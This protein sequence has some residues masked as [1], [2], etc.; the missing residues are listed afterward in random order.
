MTHATPRVLV[1]DDSS[2]IRKLVE[3]SVR[4]LPW[5]VD[6]AQTGAEGLER[7]R[8]LEP[9]TILLDVVLPDL[10]GLDV[11]QSL[12]RDERTARASIVLMTGKD[13][14]I[15]EQ[16]REHKQVVGYL[17]KPFTAAQLLEQLHGV[18]A[19]APALRDRPRPSA[20]PSDAR[21][22]MAQALYTRLKPHLAFIPEWMEQLGSAQPA[23][24]FAR[25]LLSP[26][27]IDELVEALTPHLGV[28]A[29][30]QRPS[31]PFAGSVRGFPLL[32]I[33]RALAAL[34]QRS[35]VL[36]LTHAP[37]RSWLYFRRGA[38][39]L[40]TTDDVSANVP[41]ES[42]PA[43]PTQRERALD[44]QRASGKPYLVSLAESGVVPSATL[45][46]VLH[47]LGSR[48]LARL[49]DAAELQFSW[50]EPPTLPLFVEANGRELSLDQL[51][52]EHLR[53]APAPEVEPSEAV[54]ERTPGFSRRV[55]HFS[56][57]AIER[58]VLALVDGSH[59]TA[60]ICRRTGFGEREVSAVL[61]RLL[62]VGLVRRVDRARAGHKVVVIDHGEVAE[63]L[64]PLLA[65]LPGRWTV[66][67]F[68]PHQRDLVDAV[69]REAP[70]VL[71]ICAGGVPPEALEALAALAE[72][73]ATRLRTLV[74]LED[75]KQLQVESLLM[76]GFDHVLVK[77]VSFGEIER[78]VE[79]VH[80]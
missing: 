58:S 26:E 56:L 22:T 23:A 52:L 40:V 2:T 54:F 10:R 53:R 49:V 76:S 68:P 6:Y 24:F 35:G 44:E 50:S 11:C 51:K 60:R 79:E 33:L 78:I 1:I 72:N 67:A 20:L 45:P 9:D 18:A 36:E 17:R 5:L 75:K 37:N 74:V 21:N 32:E 16:F 63:P 31:A 34:D 48:Q 77:P 29:T 14:R 47:E 12:A 15:R 38:L 7:A 64:R 73:P 57:T 27:L 42:D 66:V 46:T 65:R 43:T 39:V 8:A 55:R 71:V 41:H 80:G 62:S 70:G 59:P 61:A 69:R 3:L 13:E 30:E 19:R 4:Q 25:K 28:R